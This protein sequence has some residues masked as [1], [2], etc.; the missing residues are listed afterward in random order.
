MEYFSSGFWP[1]LPKARILLCL[2]S[3]QRVYSSL[4]DFGPPR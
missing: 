2:G 1:C 3:L 4:R